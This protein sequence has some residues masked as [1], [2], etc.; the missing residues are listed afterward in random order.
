MVNNNFFEHDDLIGREMGENIAYTPLGGVEGCGSVYNEE[1]VADCTVSGWM[2]SIGHKENI[3]TGW[4]ICEGIG[5]A[6]SESNDVYVTQK[7]C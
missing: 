6:I 1:D 5:V 3:L 7:F 4:F 2:T